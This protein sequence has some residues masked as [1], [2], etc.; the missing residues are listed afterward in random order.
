MKKCIV[1]LIVLLLLWPGLFAAGEK[2]ADTGPITLTYWTH[3]DPNR[4]ALEERLIREFE[5]ENSNVTIERVTHASSRISELI[6]T[7]FAANM[8]PDL[9][10]LPIEDGYAYI[11]NQRVAQINPGS[12][13]YSSITELKNAYVKGVL[14]PVTMDGKMFGLPLEL[15]N[16]SIYMNDRV[17]KDAGL[18]PNKDYPKTWE[19]MVNVSE[20]I[21]IRDGNIVTRRGFDFRYPYYLVSMVPMVEQLGGELINADGTEV[22]IGQDAWI[23]FLRFMQGWGPNGKNLGSPTYQ[24]ARKLFNHDNNDIAMTL[25]GLYQQGR[26]KADNPEFYES[27]EWRV[28]PFPVF[29]NAVQNTAACYY[30]H[31]LMVNAQSSST[32]QDIAWKFIAYMLQ[33]SEEY[34][35]NVGLI[36][37]TKALMN[38]ELYKSMPYSD[39]FSTDMERAHVVYHAA[40]SAKLQELVKTAVEDVMVGGVTPE[41]AYATLKAQAQELIEED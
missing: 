4:T 21:V 35:E 14:D 23:S 11:S 22:I 39:V 33:H 37:P 3:E 25:S 30:G 29:Q 13:G 24:N 40:N 16:W 1:I 18:N 5:T 26:I 41:K 31:Y 9:F 38:S 36:Q 7:A 12:V 10:N 19:E 20:K 34:L 8:G 27:G 17:F 15:T 32:K 2:E 28:I 6:L